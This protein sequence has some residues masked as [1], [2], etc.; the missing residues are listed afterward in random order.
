MLLQDAS[1]DVTWRAYGG[2]WLEESVQARRSRLM[3]LAMRRKTVP[4]PGLS[5]LNR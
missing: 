5:D 3:V 4:V 2:P 1:L